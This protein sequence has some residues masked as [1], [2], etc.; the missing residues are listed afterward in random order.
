MQKKIIIAPVDAQS[1]ER[2][3]FVPIREFP[4]ERVVLL[5]SAEGL[6]RAEELK[7]KL[8]GLSIPVSV[9]KVA[10]SDPWEDYFTVV[11]DIIE[12]HERGKVI[13]NIATADRISQ[14]ALTNAAH[15]NGIKA[16]AVIDGKLMALPILKLSFS[17]VLSPRK[18]RI[19]DDLF[20]AG[21]CYS[22]MEE[23]S[24]KSGMSLQLLSY[25]LNGTAKSEG[26]V[27]LELVDTKEEKGRVKVCLSTMG[28]LFMKG[29]LRA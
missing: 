15:V 27:Q 4:T 28:R 1:S 19:L 10:G 18:M 3:L 23:L 8:E 21:M 29:Y 16:V 11:S 13:I 22:S 20:K 14:C 5:S 2:D 9:V 6:G 25:H 12:G 7:G 26:L 17:S 24:K